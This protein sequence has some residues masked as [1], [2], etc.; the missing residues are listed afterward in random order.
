MME[1]E[2]GLGN[3]GG[4]RA[5]GAGRVEFHRVSRRGRIFGRNV[6]SSRIKAQGEASEGD[7]THFP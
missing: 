6:S 4:A 3:L 5:H 1:A 2:L 7:I